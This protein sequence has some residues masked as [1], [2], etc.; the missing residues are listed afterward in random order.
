MLEKVAEEQRRSAEDPE[1]STPPVVELSPSPV[2]VQELP[3]VLSHPKKRTGSVTESVNFITSRDVL[4]ILH[5]GRSSH[6]GL[7][8]FAT[9]KKGQPLALPSHLAWPRCYVERDP[10]LPFRIC[11]AVETDDTVVPLQQCVDCRFETVHTVDASAWT[12]DPEVLVRAGQFG[13]I[14]LYLDGLLD[15]RSTGGAVDVGIKVE[16]PFRQWMSAVMQPLAGRLAAI[17]KNRSLQEV[18]HR[19]DLA[20]AA[21]SVLIVGRSR[22]ADRWLVLHGGKFPIGKR[23]LVGLD[24]KARGA[25]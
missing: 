1:E 2:G 17:G 5:G 22:S 3:S 24:Q 19:C 16:G 7:Y 14:S 25:T 13:P 11:F 12:R 20:S 15:R 21:E 23:V 8:R 10:E 6:S 18:V 9:W 4:D